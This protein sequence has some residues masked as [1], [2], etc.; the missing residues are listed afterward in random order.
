M[1]QYVHKDVLA[2]LCTEQT[3]SN[4]GT[5]LVEVVASVLDNEVS[6]NFHQKLI[7]LHLT[8]NTKLEKKT[9]LTFYVNKNIGDEDEHGNLLASLSPLF[10]L[11]YQV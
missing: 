4:L 6:K 1:V 3:E 2:N 5:L 10:S 11:S 9:P 8:R 7:P